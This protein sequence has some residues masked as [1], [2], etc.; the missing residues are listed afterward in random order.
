MITPKSWATNTQ[1]L[2][3]FLNIRLRVSVNES[4]NIERGERPQLFVFHLGI[5]WIVTRNRCL[6]VFERSN[7]GATIDSGV[8]EE[9]R[10]AGDPSAHNKGYNCA[11]DLQS[12]LSHYDS[13]LKNHVWNNVACHRS[14]SG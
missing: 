14:A 5:S 13:L 1:P 8:V 7:V 4:F 10:E 2:P 11:D 6:T 3:D 12:K 9:I